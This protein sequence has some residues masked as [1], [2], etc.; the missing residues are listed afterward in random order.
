[1]QAGG[2]DQHDD[3]L[4]R[5]PHRHEYVF[6]LLY[7]VVPNRAKLIY[8][9]IART[10]TNLSSVFVVTFVYVISHIIHSYALYSVQGALGAIWTG[11]LQ[12]IRAC[13]VFFTSG[14]LYCA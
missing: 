1:M 10:H 11:L 3:L 13:V 6:Q 5:D 7:S 8:E 2:R 4:R 9:P 12:C 14:Y